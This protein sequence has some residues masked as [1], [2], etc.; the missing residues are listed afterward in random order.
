M[1]VCQW[2]TN[3]LKKMMQTLL[4]ARPA[5]NEEGKRQKIIE[6]L[7]AKL[8]QMLPLQ[9]SQLVELYDFLSQSRLPTDVVNGLTS[10]LDDNST[11]AMETTRQHAV[12][13]CCDCLDQ[14]LNQADIATLKSV[15]MWHGC[16]ALS[17][18]LRLLGVRNLKESTKK[19][20]VAILVFFEA[21]R[22]AIPPPDSI[23]VLSQHFQTSF[24]TQNVEVPSKA[25]SLAVYPNSPSELSKE[26]LN[27][28]YGDQPPV[29][30][31]FPGLAQILKFHAPVR[32]T[33][34]GVNKREP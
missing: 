24:L 6:Q 21:E 33:N 34:K 5:L 17:K 1:S 8:K 25:V 26:H 7:Q 23:Y 29:P 15:D 30:H 32:S 28:C 2:T 16:T 10:M 11:V 4:L 13:Q 27:A 20:A 19:A 9:P 14:Y 31:Q 3:D 22:S 12:P 18:R